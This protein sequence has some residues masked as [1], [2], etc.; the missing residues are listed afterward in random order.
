MPYSS[1]NNTSNQK[2]WH[3]IPYYIRVMTSTGGGWGDPL[4]R[5]VALVLDDLK[6]GYISF[7]QAQKQYGVVVNP[8]TLQVERFVGGR[9][10]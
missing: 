9:Q 4:K 7:D 2:P 1:A 8:N 3:H 10:G 5:P 6:N